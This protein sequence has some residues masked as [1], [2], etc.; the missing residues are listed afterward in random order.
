[1]VGPVEATPCRTITPC[2]APNRACPLLQR[3]LR[4]S[5]RRRCQQDGWRPALARAREAVAKLLSDLCPIGV[6]QREIDFPTSRADRPIED[7]DATLRN[8]AFPKLGCPLL[9]Q[10]KLRKLHHHNRAALAPER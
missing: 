10:L 5:H 6:R 3:V 2:S 7:D 1:M 8:S 9:N 4:P